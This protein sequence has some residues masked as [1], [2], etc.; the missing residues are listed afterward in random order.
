MTTPPSSTRRAAMAVGAATAAAVAGSIPGSRPARAA[1]RPLDLETPEGNLDG[2]LKTRSD[3]G[4]KPS[5]TWASGMVYTH[6][7][8]RASRTLMMG[9]ALN[10]TRCIKDA[11]GYQFLQRECLIWSDAATGEPLK[12][13][14][15]PFIDREVEV[16][17][18]QNASVSSH[19][20]INGARGPYRMNYMEHSGDVTFYNDLFY[21]SASPLNIDEY[22]AYAAASDYQGAGLYHWH[23]RRADLD[24]ADISSAPTTTSHIG[25][26]QWLPWM[27]MGAWAGELVLPNRGKK[28][29]GGVAEV[30][31]AFRT[32]LEKN[33]PEYLEP[34]S[35]EQKEERRSFYGEFKKH[36]D[37]KRALRAPGQ[38]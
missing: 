10:V 34:P 14:F 15:N 30:P 19:Y 25:V 36:I 32:W 4:G 27:E 13:W 33:A 23:T 12:T 24:N 1:T 18:I 9:Q 21:K 6:I 2:Y 31:K 7:P 11:T 16:F 35:L 38:K 29:L 5:Y 8:G 28:L 37:A 17:H 20:D 26:R 3:I 22:P